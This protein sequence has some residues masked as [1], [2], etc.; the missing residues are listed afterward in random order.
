MDK[1]DAATP[2]VA[3]EP[4]GAPP[5]R[6]FWRRPKPSD[7]D[8]TDWRIRKW[9]ELW[10]TV[11]L[12][13]ATLVTAWAGYEASKWNG[14]QTSLNLQATAMRID[15]TRLASAAQ[16]QRLVDVT[17]FVNWANAVGSGNARL[18]DFYRERFSD[19]FQPAF[20]AWLATSPLDNPDAAGT[21][22]EMAEYR[23]PAQ[24]EADEL[25]AVAEQL[26]LSGETAGGF[27]DQFTL[28][29]VI[30]AGALLLAGL[31][32][33]FEW[34]ELRGVVVVVALLI[35]LYCVVMI[36]RLPSA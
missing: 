30:L 18:A 26:V 32:H 12:S 27:A 10:A 36:V 5:R 15:A 34:A 19:V 2:A 16:Q 22:F 28:T 11:I 8:I 35:L 4:S 20:A 21:P 25:N 14:L 31:A 9:S 6:R 29:V 13:V 17:Q 7:E 3:Q 24:V 1:N 23:L 33:R